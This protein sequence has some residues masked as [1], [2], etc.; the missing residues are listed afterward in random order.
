MSPTPGDEPIGQTVELG[1][2]ERDLLDEAESFVHGLAD[3]LRPGLLA[4]FGDAAGEFKDDDT[5]V[6]AADV[7][8]SERIA[9]AV[10]ERFPSHGIVS[11]EADT[12][13]DGSEWC[14]V[15][16]PIDGTVNFVRGVPTWTVSIALAFRGRPVLG[17]VDAPAI[18]RRYG[19]V[20]GRGARRDGRRIAVRDADLH[21]PVTVDNT[22]I[23]TSS[24]IGRHYT[25]DLPLR[26]RELGSAA[27]H[28]ALVADGSVVASIHAGQ[29]A[30]DIA[31]GQVLVTEA[32]GA[33]VH[34]D[35]SATFP[36][37]P[38]ADQ[39]DNHHRF[40]AAASNDTGRAV[41][42]NVRRIER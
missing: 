25:L 22:L 17:L 42:D 27:L 31:A 9:A 2:A 41:L 10:G 19:A 6:T 20:S 37:Q 4:V 18:D 24:G 36:M 13:F 3:D 5:M 16:D 40:V 28:L 26:P 8:T 14:W 32:G 30:W 23:A 34:H 21:D 7:E 39:A 12:V 29:R 1:D 38:G 35:E 11:E 33:L 15:V